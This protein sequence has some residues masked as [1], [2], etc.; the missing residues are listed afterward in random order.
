M[1]IVSH[2]YFNV[3]FPIKAT[4]CKRVCAAGTVAASNENFTF[5]DYLSVVSFIDYL[6]LY[7][8]ILIHSFIHSFIEYMYFTNMAA[9][10][11]MHCNC[12]H[13]LCHV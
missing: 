4:W 6:G 13:I 11:L 12:P 2:D 10:L 3:E 8:K 7:E 1:F 5:I 9:F